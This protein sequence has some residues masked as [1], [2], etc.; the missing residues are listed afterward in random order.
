[1]VCYKCNRLHI[2]I[3][4]S[5]ETGANDKQSDGGISSTPNLHNF[6]ED[7]ESVL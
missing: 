5:P 6:M 7:S 2:R 1:M 3:K 4:F